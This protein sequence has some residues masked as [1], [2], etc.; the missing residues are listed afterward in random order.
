M[1]PPGPKKNPIFRR[2]EKWLLDPDWIPRPGGVP[3]TPVTRLRKF[4][5][6]LKFTFMMGCVLINTAVQ[7]CLFGPL[8]IAL[9]L[10][11]IFLVYTV[12]NWVLPAP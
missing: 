8:L 5:R 12:V 1:S 11:F 3:I 10:T 7:F 6:A 4:T 2:I 9:Y